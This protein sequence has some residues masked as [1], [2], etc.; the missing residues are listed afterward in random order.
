MVDMIVLMGGKSLLGLV[1]MGEGHTYRFG[2]V[3]GKRF[4]DPLAGGIDPFRRR[5]AGLGPR[6]PRIW[7][8]RNLITISKA[9][10][11]QRSVLRRKNSA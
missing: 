6:F 5:F 2:A 3:D 11:A 9:P 10:A 7:L 8:L 4:A 1:P